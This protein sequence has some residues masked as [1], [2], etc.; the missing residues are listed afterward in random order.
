MKKA[1]FTSIFKASMEQATIDD[2][3]RYT[4]FDAILPQET[5]NNHQTEEIIISTTTT[6]PAPQPQQSFVSM[7]DFR[8]P[9]ELQ[10]P[11]IVLVRIQ[12]TF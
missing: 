11:L 3:K 7:S 12:V 1:F 2:S 4:D 5:N 10:I 6:T 8:V 9:P